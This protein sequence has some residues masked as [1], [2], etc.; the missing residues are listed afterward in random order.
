M[1]F[2]NRIEEE[3][4]KT[5]EWLIQEFGDHM[6]IHNALQDHKERV[7]AAASEHLID[8][9]AVVENVKSGTEDPSGNPALTPKP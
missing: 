3:V 7:L 6:S 1:S 2:L 9:A 8:P 5:K 4:Q